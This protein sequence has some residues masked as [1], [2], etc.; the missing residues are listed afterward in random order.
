MF[1]IEDRGRWDKNLFLNVNAL[2]LY[3]TSKNFHDNVMKRFENVIATAKEE[4]K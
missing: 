2:L 1:Y 4:M 3:A